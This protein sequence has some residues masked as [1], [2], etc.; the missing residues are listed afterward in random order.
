MQGT[1]FHTLSRPPSQAIGS[2]AHNHC[3][4]VS[5]QAKLRLLAQLG[6]DWA[7]PRHRVV[8]N[9][10][11]R[12]NLKVRDAFNPSMV[13][14]NAGE[15]VQDS[16]SATL[17]HN[18][19]QPSILQTGPLSGYDTSP[20]APPQILQTASQFASNDRDAERVVAEGV[21]ANFPT[22]QDCLR[23]EGPGAAF[24][25][26]QDMGTV[27]QK[28]FRSAKKNDKT[29][30]EKAPT[31]VGEEPLDRSHCDSELTGSLE[32]AESPKMSEGEA[33]EATSEFPSGQRQSQNAGDSRSDPTVVK[34]KPRAR[35]KK[36]FSCFKC[37]RKKSNAEGHGLDDNDD[38]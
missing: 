35:S 19:V 29:D 30:R 15:I 14:P 27:R 17:S 32:M 4:I 2:P 31:Q 25:S 6:L 3:F 21:D 22:S 12:L 7:L 38:D 24:A 8:S 33:D 23:T 5:A 16:H 20:P 18:V 11:E 10:G 13:S 9:Q 28:R 34:P 1:D 36:M 26:F 37:G